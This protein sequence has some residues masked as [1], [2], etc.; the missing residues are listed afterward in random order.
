MSTMKK[1]RAEEISNMLE[2][3]GMIVDVIPKPGNRRVW[4]VTF[5]IDGAMKDKFEDIMIDYRS[6]KVK[7][8]Y[9]PQGI[10]NER[11]YLY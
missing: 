10:R 1:I 11:I 5:L 2:K 8:D 4:C 6:L 9:E 3:A 7:I